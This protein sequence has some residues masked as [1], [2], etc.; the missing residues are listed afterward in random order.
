MTFSSVSSVIRGIFVNLRMDYRARLHIKCGKVGC[1]WPVMKGTL[2]GE[3]S[4]FR[5]ISRLS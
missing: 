1:D 3:R 5:S 4:T 2:Y